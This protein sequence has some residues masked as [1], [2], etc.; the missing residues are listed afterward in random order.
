MGEE[1]NPVSLQSANRH[2]LPLRFADIKVGEHEKFS[3]ADSVINCLRTLHFE[4]VTNDRAFQII[5]SHGVVV[6]DDSEIRD[7]VGKPK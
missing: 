2:N 3:N 6:L 1:R 7:R 4:G 5:D